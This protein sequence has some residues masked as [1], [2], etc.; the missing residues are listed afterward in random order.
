MKNYTLVFFVYLFIF[1][2]DY[3]PV[4]AQV[5]VTI[6]EAINKAADLSLSKKDSALY[7][8]NQALAM[9]QKV[10][11]SLL[12]FYAYRAIGSIYEDNNQLQ[13]AKTAYAAAL[14]LANTRLQN[15]EQLTIYTDWAIIHKKLGQYTIAQDFHLRAIKQAEKT[16]HWEMAEDNYHGLGTLYAMLSDF[17]QSV[18]YYLA[19]IKAAEKWG[20][21]AGIVFSQ[22]NISST[23]LKAKSYDRALQN[24]EKTYQLALK[25]GDSLRLASVLRVYGNIKTALGDYHDALIKHE[26]AKV[27]FEK[28]H[29]EECLAESYLSLGDVHFKWGNYTKAEE[30]FSNCTKKVDFLGNYARAE[31]FNKYGKLF[32]AQ[33]KTPL[34]I[35]AF[36]QS[37]NLTDTLGF[38]EIARENHLAL[39]SIFSEQKIAD[40]AYEHLKMADK[41]GEEL[42]QEKNQK[43]LVEAQFKFD[44]EKR[45]IQ[46]DA[47]QQQL[48]QFNLIR[49]ILICGLLALATVLYYTWKQMRAKQ[50]ANNR[51]ELIIKEL[52]HRVKNN[53]QTIASMMR[54]QARQAQDPLVSA[55][56]LENKARLETFS[57]LH[58][59]LYVSDNIE[60]LNL[61]PFI[62]DIIE[63]V[64]YSNGLDNTQ[65]K[66]HL[67]L[68]NTALNVET[69]LS[70]GLILNELLTNSLKYAYP[71]LNKSKPLEI[72]IDILKDRFHYADNG[73]DLPLDFDFKNNAGFGI[74]FIASF[75]H[76][77]KGKYKFFVDKGVHFDLLFP[78]TGNNTVTP[79]VS[80]V[81][82]NKAAVSH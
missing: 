17:D 55:I 25:L 81:R 21:Q 28:I 59:Q 20:N 2:F 53:M 10:D 39:A 31:C 4:D 75:A 63:K 38:N 19:S 68:E 54:L 14:T 40:L 76:Q 7:Y 64:R 67:R 33:A 30:Y 8:A 52:H 66:T 74:Q 61:Q 12:I 22:Q 32:Q 71:S 79:P 72:N 48:S 73:E 35:A 26:A 13:D 37:L 6:V 3:T 82:T 57:M 18:S 45:D 47:Q 15:D 50:D 27:I 46:I 34:A 11:S 44:V 42:F 65:L 9:A 80:K 49:W 77:I 5:Q 78:T 51:N 41:L 70:V 23:Y 58:Q 60:T 29:N 1:L 36:Q 24:I 43:S 62:Q 69:A 56:L 16:A